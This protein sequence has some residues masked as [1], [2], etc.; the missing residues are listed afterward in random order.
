MKVL[1]LLLTAVAFYG[2]LIIA[3]PLPTAQAAV[4]SVQVGDGQ[5]CDYVHLGW[6][7]V[8]NGQRIAVCGYDVRDHYYRWYSI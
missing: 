7:L 1:T 5:N 6:Y 2:I 8:R 3:R 4:I